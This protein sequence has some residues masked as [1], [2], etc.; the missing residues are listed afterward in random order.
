MCSEE[1]LGRIIQFYSP[2][3]ILILG[4]IAAERF[5]R[6][7]KLSDIV[8]GRP[9]N[10]ANAEADVYVLYHPS[11]RNGHRYSE[12]WYNRISREIGAKIKKL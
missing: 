5:F 4:G 3:I 1:Y 2:K 10:I 11:W 9:R 7:K 8:D 12:E 6:F